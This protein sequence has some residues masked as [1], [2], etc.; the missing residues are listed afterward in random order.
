[1]A[2]KTVMKLEVKWVPLSESTERGRPQWLN[3]WFRRR[4]V[5]VDGCVIGCWKAVNPLGKRASDCEEVFV[6]S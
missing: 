5:V 1:M 2:Y 4:T 6:T 3:M